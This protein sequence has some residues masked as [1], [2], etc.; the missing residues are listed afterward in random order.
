[1]DVGRAEEEEE[2]SADRL[3][4]DSNYLGNFEW[5]ESNDSIEENCQW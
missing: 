5:V 2:E 4:R 1:M 3:Q